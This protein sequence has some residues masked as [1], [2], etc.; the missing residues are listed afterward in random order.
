MQLVIAMLGLQSKSLEVQRPDSE[1][2]KAPT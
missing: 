2:V 1:V